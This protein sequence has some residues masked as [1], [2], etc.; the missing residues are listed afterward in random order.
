LYYIKHVKRLSNLIALQMA[1][2]VIADRGK[3]FSNNFISG[4]RFLNPVFSHGVNPRRQ[5]MEHLLGRYLFDNGYQFYP[6]WVSARNQRRFFYPLT[7]I[8]KVFFD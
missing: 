4:L 2:H 6:P 1:D 8:F 3:F 7:N 5:R